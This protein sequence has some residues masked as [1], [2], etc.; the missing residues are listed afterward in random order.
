MK[1]A[2]KIQIICQTPNSRWQH[3]SI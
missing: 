1:L 3:S 2:L